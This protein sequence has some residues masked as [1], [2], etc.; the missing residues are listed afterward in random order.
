MPRNSNNTNANGGSQ[1]SS[2]NS[3]SGYVPPST[4]SCYKAYGGQQN[5]MR[6]IGLKTYDSEA[7]DEARQIVDAFKANDRAEWEAAN[8]GKGK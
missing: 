6:S 3:D 8:K 7:Y 4:A 2:T 5:S 1:R